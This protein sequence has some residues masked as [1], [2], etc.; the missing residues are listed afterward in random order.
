MGSGKSAVTARLLAVL[1][2]RGLVVRGLDHAARPGRLG[3][4]AWSIAFAIRHPRVL[5]AAA[6]AAVQAPVP[7]SHRCT[8]LGLVLGLGGRL[9]LA[10]RS[11]GADHWLV[12]DEGLV[13]RAVT[14]F[15]WRDEVPVEEVRDY[16]GSLPIDGMVLVVVTTSSDLAA[17]RAAQRGHPRRLG[18]R[19]PLGDRALSGRARDIILLAADCARDR[20]L[21]VL[22]VNNSRSLGTA[23]T[24]AA[25]GVTRLVDGE[26]SSARLP[27]EPWEPAL[28]LLRPDRALGFRGARRAAL[29]A[30]AV[31]AILSAYGLVPAGL[32]RRLGSA[33]ARGDSVR[34][35]TTV[36]QVVVKRYK[37]SVTNRA[38]AVEHSVLAQ[39]ETVE[40]P[41]PRLRRM[42]SG[43]TSVEFAGRQHAVYDYLEGYRDPRDFLMGPSDRRR[44]DMLA[45]TALAD[46]HLVLAEHAPPASEALGFARRGGDRVRPMTWYAEQ[47]ASVAAPRRVRAWLESAL[48][49]TWDALERERLPITVIHGDFG[50][51]NLLVK[52][53]KRLVV[54]DFELARLDW[55]TADLAIALPRF[56]V[57]RFGADIGRAR[58]FLETY[59]RR[60]GATRAELRRIPDVLAFLSID[61]AVVAWGRERDGVP[62]DW[63]NEARRRVMLAEDLLGGHHLVNAVVG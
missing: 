14:L 56:A 53:G 2:Q 32:P 34:V 25:R 21:T 51:H 29:P 61:R 40:F 46:L 45:A 24:S 60:S 58:H 55:R 35:R 63:G 23:V 33:T 20:G 49:R 30:P 42:P 52:P 59:R 6:W 11:L 12:L 8:A 19:T 9:L 18:T 27:A 47:L 38:V 62:G 4:S 26:G 17:R 48:W 16:V 10:S 43:V 28:R 15:G 41:A 39:L 37:Q 36:G 7:W 54:V 50:W 13:Q 1:D 22:R 5:V 57:S 31:S 44:V 3:A